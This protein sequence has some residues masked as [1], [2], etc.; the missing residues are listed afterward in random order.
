LPFPESDDGSERESGPDHFGIKPKQQ[1][2]NPASEMAV[3]NRQ[4]PVAGRRMLMP[5]FEPS[6]FGGTIFDRQPK[7]PITV[8]SKS[9]IP[10]DLQLHRTPGPERC[11]KWP[12]DRLRGS[13]EGSDKQ[14][15]S[16][17]NTKLAL[18]NVKADQG[19]T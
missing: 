2:Q 19:F 15:C 4:C 12:F 16:A 9:L 13:R 7:T 6:A 3:R 5:D 10:F 11:R 17:K 1:R 14:H 8:D 18:E